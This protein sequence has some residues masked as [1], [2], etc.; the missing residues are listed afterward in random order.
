M[1]DEN[2]FRLWLTT[3]PYR[4]Q[5]VPVARLGGWTEPAS[6]PALVSPAA[7]QE[8]LKRTDWPLHV[9]AARPSVWGRYSTEGEVHGSSMYRVEER[10]GVEFRPFVA[11][12][13]P[14]G[15]PA[16]LEPIQAFV[17]HWEAWP[18]HSGDGSI[19]WFEDGDDS[20]PVEIAR[21]I[22]ER[23][24]DRATLGRLEIRR[25]RLLSF[26]ASFGF[27]LAI[28]HDARVDCDLPDRWRDDGR[29]EHRKWETWAA[30]VLG[31]RTTAVLRAVTTI[32]APRRED[33]LEP[34]DSEDRSGVEYPVGVDASTGNEI[35][36]THPPH[37]FLAPVFF[38][39]GVLERYYANPL[40]Y[41]V[42]DT[43]IHGGRQWT[44]PIA[45]TGR[46]TIQVWLG[47]IAGLPRSVQQ[48]WQ[49]YAV[50]DE[51]GVPEWRVRRDLGAEFVSAPIHGPVAELKRVITEINEVAIAQFGFP[52][53][54]DID[55]MHAQSISVLRI[56]PNPSMDAFVQ[57]IRPLALLV[58]DHL[59]PRFLDAA[60][61]PA[62]AGTL[63]RLALLIRDRTGIDEAGAREL[64][65]SLYA[66]QALRTT[67]TAHR[68]GAKADE[69]L[70]RAQIS[71]HDLPAGFV[72]LVE[73]AVQSM[74]RLRDEISRW[75]G[76]SES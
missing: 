54:A 52:M 33:V 70:A 27:D 8:V 21:W 57:Q 5:W 3:D 14:Y 44:L 36:V 74:R 22:V 40:L 65:G 45:R 13:S 6:C 11:S 67:L 73:G 76:I 31:G 68:T 55:R 25:N 30:T 58:V 32:K 47:D 37:P 60:S 1:K 66:I 9:G 43:S 29:D 42:S 61:A 7:E 39:E 4:G 69:A 15:G 51:G 28:Y 19:A 41:R 18:R 50:V 71:I 24:E 38:R 35:R 59:N 17:L 75:A 20:D 62:A 26:L 56:P 16:W 46:G 48:H 72:R 49:Q 34:W 63:N 2:P 23:H 10:E 53:I 64:I 12:F